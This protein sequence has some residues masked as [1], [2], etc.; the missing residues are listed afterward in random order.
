[1]SEHTAKKRIF[2]QMMNDR[3]CL[4]TANRLERT[5]DSS[6]ILVF[7][8]SELV[9]MFDSPQVLYIYMTETTQAK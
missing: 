8:G 2:V 9:G 1:M 7:N 4:L 5:E 6:F 3:S